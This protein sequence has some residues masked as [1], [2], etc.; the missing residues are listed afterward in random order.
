MQEMGGL[1]F[2]GT[3]VGEAA[4]PERSLAIVGARPRPRGAPCWAAALDRVLAIIGAERR[5]RVVV[6]SALS[7]VTDGLLAIAARSTAEPRVSLEALLE[8]HLDA[9]RLVADDTARAGLERELRGIAAHTAAVLAVSPDPLSA[10]ACDEV[11]A[12]GELW[13]SRLLAAR[14]AGQGIP[15]EWIDVRDVLKTD[16]NHG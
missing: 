4:A 7:G 12:A 9:A 3:S 15:A 6:V 2:G 14:L 5:P 8:R 1:K 10:A 13:S 11:V 16:S